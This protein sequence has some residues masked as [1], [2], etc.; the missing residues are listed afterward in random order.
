MA[1][2]VKFVQINR[3]VDYINKLHYLDAIDEDGRWWYA[4]MDAD[5]NR[6]GENH[7]VFT[8]HGKWQPAYTQPRP[9]EYN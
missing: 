9:L 1:N 8:K 4:V 3:T 6:T 2:R 5:K 7:L